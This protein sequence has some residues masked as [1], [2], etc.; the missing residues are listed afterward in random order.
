MHQSFMTKLA[1]GKKLTKTELAKL[2]RNVL[3][4]ASVVLK[5]RVAVAFPNDNTVGQSLVKV[6]IDFHMFLHVFLWSWILWDHNRWL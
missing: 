4:D 1:P 5:R 3:L 6:L 2:S